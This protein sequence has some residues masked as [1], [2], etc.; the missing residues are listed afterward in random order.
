MSPKCLVRLLTLNLLPFIMSTITFSAASGTTRIGLFVIKT[1]S[2][3]LESMFASF[4][5][6]DVCSRSIPQVFACEHR[7]HISRR[8]TLLERLCSGALSLGDSEDEIM[9]MMY[10]TEQRR[11]HISVE[12]SLK[13]AVRLSQ[14]TNMSDDPPNLAYI[15]SLPFR[16]FV[17][18][19]IFPAIFIRRVN[20]LEGVGKL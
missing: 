7:S 1:N 14:T 17:F 2:Q 10:D 5:R 3:S 20:E 4:R 19:P 13:P 8:T 12:I 6:V 16:R 9:A 15:L 18:I 11:V